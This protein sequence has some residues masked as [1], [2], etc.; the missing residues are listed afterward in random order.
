MRIV[1]VSA[2]LSSPSSTRLL[3]DRLAAATLEHVDA[4]TEVVELR[5]LATEIAQHFVTGFPPARLAAALDAVAA[6]DGLI[7]VT[8]VFAGSYSGLF[9]S[10]FDLIDKDSLTAKP[11]LLGATGG[12]A[13]HS[14][15][16]EHAL[17]PLF[18]YLRALV[19]PTA[20]YAA[21][22]DWGQEGLAQ[23][24]A[25]A[26]AELARFTAPEAV[27]GRSA[28]LDLDTAAAI[29]P[30]SPTGAITSVDPADGFVTVPFE[31][32]LAALRVP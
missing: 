29:A 19:L 5:E 3:A 1:V 11:V 21:S 10:F 16:T 8:P 31:Q 13:R 32:R 20:V 14:L 17:R 9:K 28:A 25:R 15:V 18:T 2:G 26:G 7:A 22:E 23:R 4:E 12:T 27:P 30:R 24:I 6:A